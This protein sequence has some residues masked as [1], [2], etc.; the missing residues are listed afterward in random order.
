MKPRAAELVAR[1]GVLIIAHRGA[2]GAAPENTLP[3]FRAA[4]VAGADLVELDTRHSLDDIPM[5]FHDKV[6]DRTTDAPARWGGEQ[7]RLGV[8]RAAE[9]AV[10][11]AG[12][13]RDP[14]FAGTTIPTLEQA[15][16]VIQPGA[17]TLIERKTGDAQTL[18]RLLEKHALVEHVV[19]Q[20]FDWEF[21]AACRAGSGAVVLGALGSKALGDE[22]LAAIVASGATVVGWNHKHLDEP[23]VRRVHA[24]GLKL[25]AYTVNDAARAQTLVAWG[26]DGLIT[27]EPAA[28]RAAVTR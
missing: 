21:L 28:M 7:L 3:A 16:E 2:S 23:T 15:L 18:L 10:L 26:I 13:W 12:S 9:L 4:L 17:T 14:K 8:R 20:A 5:V 22:R 27:D 1:G 11:D 24:R 19:I 6:L 25:W